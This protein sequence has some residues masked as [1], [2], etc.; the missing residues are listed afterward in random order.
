MLDNAMVLDFGIPS[1]ESGHSAKQQCKTTWVWEHPGSKNGSWQSFGASPFFV[2]QNFFR[3]PS[4]TEAE[5]L[6]SIVNVAFLYTLPMLL[7][8][9]L[10]SFVLS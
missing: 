8:S 1:V 10:L 4:L 7:I 2:S 6:A 3:K 5:F 9:W